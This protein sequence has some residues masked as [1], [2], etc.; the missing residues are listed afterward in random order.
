MNLSPATIIGSGEEAVYLYYYENDRR[1]A[2]LEGRTRWEC[3]IGKAQ[4]RSC[5]RVADQ[6]RTAHA[7][8][9][10]LAVEV[11]T[12]ASYSLESLLHSKMRA[13]KIEGGS[14][15]EWFMTNPDDFVKLCRST[16][17]SLS[18]I[19]DACSFDPNSMTYQVSELQDWGIALSHAR[20]ASEMTQNELASLSGNRQ[21]TISSIERGDETKLRT[22][23]NVFRVL[24]YSA[25]LIK[26]VE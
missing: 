21:A 7:R 12:D 15:D 9:P 2:M 10:V 25:I 26:D 1:L 18:E 3:K 23:W 17:K 8:R 24:G 4:A 11:R 5:G 16:I 14:G 6:T 20:A 22:I 19:R 13:L